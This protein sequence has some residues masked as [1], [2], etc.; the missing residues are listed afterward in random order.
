MKGVAYEFGS[1]HWRRLQGNT[2]A[3]TASRDGTQLPSF[4]AP[5]PTPARIT[6]LTARRVEIGVHLSCR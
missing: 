2:F 1:F 4:V 3:G 5:K 6:L